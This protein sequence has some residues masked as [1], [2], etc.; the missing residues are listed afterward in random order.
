M[1]NQIFIR[2]NGTDKDIR[3]TTPTERKTFYIDNG[4]GLLGNIIDKLLENT[5][6]RG[7]IY[8]K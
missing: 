3:D 5:K 2:V 4:S 6:T 1:E 7:V 8:Y